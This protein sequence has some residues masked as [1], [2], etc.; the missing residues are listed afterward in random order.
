MAI[1]LDL[2]L[3][4]PYEFFGGFKY[5]GRRHYLHQFSKPPIRDKRK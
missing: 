3:L 5:L 1:T 2:L 4:F